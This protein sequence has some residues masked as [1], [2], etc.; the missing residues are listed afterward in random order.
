MPPPYTQGEFAK[1]HNKSVSTVKG[2]VADGRLRVQRK[3][4][5]GQRAAIVLIMQSKWPKPLG[6]GGQPTHRQKARRSPRQPKGPK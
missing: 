5:R 6:P 1:L 4:G 3:G 2:L